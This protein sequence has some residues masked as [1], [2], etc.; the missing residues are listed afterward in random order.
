MTV[1]LWRIFRLVV[2]W[3]SNNFLIPTWNLN[4]ASVLNDIGWSTWVGSCKRGKTLDSLKFR[5]KVSCFVLKKN[6]TKSNHKCINKCPRNRPKANNNTTKRPSTSTKSKV[7]LQAGTNPKATST[8]MLGRART[9]TKIKIS[10]LYLT[11]Q[12]RLQ[13]KSPQPT[14]S[15]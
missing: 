12:L 6:H 7:V 15:T 8:Y 13:T 5:P 3:P 14:N 11:S 1:E 4:W 10:I 9:P 2:N